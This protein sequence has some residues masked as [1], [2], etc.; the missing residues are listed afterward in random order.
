MKTSSIILGS[1]FAGTILLLSAESSEAQIWKKIKNEVQSRAENN[2]IRKS[3]DATDKAIDKTIGGISKGSD[4]TTAEAGGSSED[5]NTNSSE[6][7]STKNVA[8]SDYKNYDFVPG[9]KIIFEPDLS[10]EPDAEIPARF[11]LI[12]GNAEIESEN[13]EKFL[14]MERGSHEVVAPLM[15][16]DHYLPDQFTLEFDI[17]YETNDERFA[18]VNDFTVQF[19]KAG[20]HNFGNW[21]LF[22]FTIDNNTRGLLGP[23]NGNSTEFPDPLGESM[24][25]IGKWHHVAIYVRK[26]I[27]KAYVD[28]YR[29][30]VSN[31]LPTGAGHLALSGDAHY[32]FKIKNFR[33]AAGGDDKY[34]KIVTDGKFIT[35]GIL[36]D[37]NKSTIKPE[38]MGTLNEIAKM[39]KNHN[40][41]KFEIDGYTDS[42][43]SDDANLKLSQQRADAVKAKLTEMGIDASRLSSK[44]FGESKPMDT[45]ETAEGKA[46]NRRVEFVKIK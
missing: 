17:M 39:M 40:D 3:G 6:K 27:G 29:V 46:N 42:D 38:S 30:A 11:S 43:G 34:N 22:Q 5:A 45:N 24:R 28:Q 7:G 4:N 23:T 12:E 8:V 13:G 10:Q 36:F 37:I 26:N 44:G 9:D 21:P 31:T 20:D 18:Y 15:N 33:L 2:I 16:S 41:L 14:R 35:H 32:G 1:F 25:T 19:R